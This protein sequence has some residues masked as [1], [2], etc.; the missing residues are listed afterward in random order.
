MRLIAPNCWVTGVDGFP[1]C[2]SQRPHGVGEALF[3]TLLTV[4]QKCQFAPRFT[5]VGGFRRCHL[6]CPL[7]LTSVA[8]FAV[9]AAHDTVGVAPFVHPCGAWQAQIALAGVN[10]VLPPGMEAQLAGVV[11]GVAR[12]LGVFP[13]RKLQKIHVLPP[14]LGR[15]WLVDGKQH[16]CL[17]PDFR[18]PPVRDWVFVAGVMPHIA[19]LGMNFLV[20]EVDAA[21][22]IEHVAQSGRLAFD[23]YTRNLLTPAGLKNLINV[24][25][26]ADIHSAWY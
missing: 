20:I 8:K 7:G 16:V 12:A 3:P 13:Y 17:R 18:D 23:P 15:V 6:E 26:D 5:S 22:P 10:G 1:V 2:D 21:A 19:V 4:T 11:E 24:K 9:T 25:T 14:A